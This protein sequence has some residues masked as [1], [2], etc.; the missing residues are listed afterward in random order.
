MK[1]V[2]KRT[3]RILW[4]ALAGLTGI[5]IVGAL[6]LAQYIPQLEAYRKTIEELVIEEVDLALVQDG[7]FEGSFEAGFVAANVRVLVRDHQI[8]D[9]DLYR[10]QHGRGEK[11]EAVV[12]QV[13]YAQSVQVDLI[14]G[15]TSSSKVILKAI[16]NALRQG[17]Q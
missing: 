14:T 16:E 3:R 17:M 12:G 13:I 6:F 4:I 11:A 7:T 1:K 8:V 10:H 15:A 9:I 2:K 5:V